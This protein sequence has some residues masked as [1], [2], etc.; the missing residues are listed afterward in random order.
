MQCEAENEVHLHRRHRSQ[1]PRRTP[2][3]QA[4]HRAHQYNMGEQ[5]HKVGELVG[6]DAGGGGI[7]VPGTMRGAGGVFLLEAGGHCELEEISTFN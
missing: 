5:A 1:F 2:L 6:A 3:L 7:G 4:S